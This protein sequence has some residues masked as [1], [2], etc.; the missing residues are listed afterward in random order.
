MT[1]ERSSDWLE[2]LIIEDIPE[3]EAADIFGPRPRWMTGRRRK[4]LTSAEAARLDAWLIHRRIRQRQDQRRRDQIRL[5]G[6]SDRPTR[7]EVAE[8]DGWTCGI[9]GD[10]VDPAYRAP[11]PRAASVDHIVE[12]AAGGIDTLDNVRLT[13]LYCNMDRGGTTSPEKAAARLASR[14]RSMTPPVVTGV[15]PR[16]R[17]AE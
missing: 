11:D 8:R 13:H 7:A 2:R 14:V 3:A 5:N 6:P 17:I 1:N 16:W 9:C 15:E 12:I 4:D 10:P